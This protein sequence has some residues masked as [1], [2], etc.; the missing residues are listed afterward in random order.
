[1]VAGGIVAL[2]AMLALAVDLGYW[3]NQQR[4]EQSAA[5]SAAMARSIAL[6]YPTTAATPA[7]IQVKSAAAL[8][9]TKNGYSDD[10][11]VTT[12]IVVNSP[13]QSGSHTADATAVEAIVSKK[14]PV[15][16]AGIF[17]LPSQTVTARAVA[18]HVLDGVPACFVQLNPLSSVNLNSGSINAMNCSVAANGLVAVGGSVTATGISYYGLIRPVIGTAYSGTETS[19]PTPI[20]DPCLRIPG[21]AYLSQQSYPLVAPANATPASSTM[22]APS[23]PGYLDVQGP[24]TS[25]TFFNPGI[26]YIYGGI[27][28]SVAGTGVTIVNVNGGATL[29]GSSSATVTAPATGPSA[30]VAYYQPSSNALPFSVGGSTTTWN[31]LFYAPSANF[32]S[33]GK[34]DNYSELVVGGITVTGQKTLTINPSLSPGLSAVQA[35]QGTTHAALAE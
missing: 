7:P 30:G 6:Y 8:A 19:V 3:R 12:T 14:Q 29:G 5:D 31:G 16:F 13:P 10:N 32:T 22:T 35:A 34:L 4:Q 25:A 9:A 15:F 17:G 21:C 27:S 11:G 23:S 26:Y 28:A 18:S 2:L 1:M 24:I 20:T 33:N